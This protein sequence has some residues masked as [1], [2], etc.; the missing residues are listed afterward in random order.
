MGMLTVSGTNVAFA[1][2]TTSPPGWTFFVIAVSLR[3]I[4]AIG[5]SAAT[6]ASYAYVMIQFSDRIADVYV[7]L[8]T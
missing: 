1:F 6:V 5:E 8:N 2:M 4:C 7:N 3:L